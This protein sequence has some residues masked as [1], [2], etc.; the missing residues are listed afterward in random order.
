METAASQIAVAIIKESPQLSLAVLLI[1][2]TFIF[3]FR[4][5]PAVVSFMESK[6]AAFAARESRKRKESEER[7]RR[8]GEWL[9]ALNQATATNSECVRV[10]DRMNVK[11]DRDE[12]HYLLDCERNSRLE[13]QLDEIDKGVTRL[14]ERR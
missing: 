3:I 2:L 9:Q 6:A 1:V 7:T 11:L 13:S 8:E 4:I 14:L 10:I 5:S 12:E